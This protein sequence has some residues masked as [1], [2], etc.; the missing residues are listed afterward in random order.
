M[1]FHSAAFMYR[2]EIDGLRALA[3]IPV[4]FFH[5]GFSLFSGGF[6][7]VDVFFVISGY[8]ITSILLRELESGSFSILRFYERRAKRILPALFFILVCCLPMA[9]LLL[10]PDE[11]KGFGASLFSVAVF[12]S[13]IYFWRNTD[14]FA[15]AA[16]DQPL[17]HTWSLS[18]EEQFY[19]FFPFFLLLIW[20]LWRTKAIPIMLIITLISLALFKIISELYPAAGFFSLVTRMWELL[21]GAIIAVYHSQRSSAEII[22]SPVRHWLA[23]TGFLMISATIVLFD[24]ISSSSLFFT[25]GAVVGSTLIIAFASEANLTGRAL[26][27][28]IP[29]AIGLCSYSIYLWHQPVFAFAR[30]RVLEPLS[31]NYYLGLCALTLVL[32]ILTLKYIETPFRRKKDSQSSVF[33]MASAGLFIVAL[34]GLGAY[35]GNGLEFRLEKKE[36]EL[37]AN[38]SNYRSESRRGE[39]FLTSSANSLALEFSDKCYGSRNP[40]SHSMYLIGDSHAAALYQS[41]NTLLPASFEIIQLTMSGCYPILGN[42]KKGPLHCQKLSDLRFG[43]IKSSEKDVVVLHANW[44]ADQLTDPTNALKADLIR[45]IALVADKVPRTN[46]VL[47]GCVPTWT[48][49]LPKYL[50]K[51]GLLGNDTGNDLIRNPDL[52]IRNICNNTLNKLAEEQNISFLNPM[53][54]LCIRDKCRYKIKD[55]HGVDVLTTWDQTHLTHQGANLVVEQLLTNLGL[56]N[57]SKAKI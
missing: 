49:T 22:D 44:P 8:L 55:S 5:A 37:L 31:S 36:A 19:L 12:A 17:L 53:N 45:T 51:K 41:I 39:C 1:S 13:N 40:A 46:I 24:P 14:Y 50:L 27:S 10:T 2:P 54:S 32:A 30:S 47:I 18:V 16:E 29:V 21:A 6:L 33:I 38:Y 42:G 26:G 35:L 52:E 25:I 7:G 43:A 9:W 20:R 4:V 28:K 15:P 57:F 48:P 56:R 3:V 34:L 11:L 23:A